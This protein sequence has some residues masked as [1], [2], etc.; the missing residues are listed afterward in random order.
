M[1]PAIIARVDSPLPE[2]IDVPVP[3]E[4]GPGE[5]LCRTLELGI[6][7]TDREILHSLKPATPAGSD[8]IVLGHECLG[9][10]EAVGA[11]VEE[12]K[13]GDLV[14]PAVRRPA[15]GQKRRLD[16][17]P[18]G[19]FTERGIWSEHGFSAEYWL[20]RPEHLYR[21][22]AEI[23]DLAVFTEPLAVSEKAVNE[24]ISLQQARLGENVWTDK[25]PSVVVTGMGPIAFA[26]IVA[27]EA[28][29]WPVVMLGRDEIDTYRARIA[30]EFGAGYAQLNEFGKLG[31]GSTAEIEDY[32]FDLILECTG[33]EEVMLEAAGL[34]RSCGIMV[35]LGSTRVPQP[36]TLNVAE[37][38]R[39]SLLGNHLFVGT[40]NAAPRD[41][42]DALTHLAQL[43][44]THAAPLAA[45]LTA[46]LS[47]TD[48]LPHYTERVPQAIKTVIRY[49]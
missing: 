40:V 30:G 7:G 22:P 31:K 8:F 10:I 34:M 11:G 18:L 17:L 13:V 6:C 41:F 32:G 46:H 39:R 21:V 29:G 19:K 38:M 48:A 12:W 4:P 33:S 26:A 36:A 24:A 2:I 5:V 16:Y 44:K 37:L 28:R 25:P 27:C 42:L 20:D 1:Q 49:S 15:A 43:K 47:M 14:V 23:A 35:W 3:R 9:R 45:L